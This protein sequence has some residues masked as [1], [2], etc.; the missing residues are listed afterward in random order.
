M[1]VEEITL[2]LP[3][4][5]GETEVVRSDARNRRRLGAAAAPLRDYRA[6]LRDC[7]R[8]CLFARNARK[9][10]SR[11]E[12]EYKSAMNQLANHVSRGVEHRHDR[13]KARKTAYNV[14]TALVEITVREREL[15]NRRSFEFV[16]WSTGLASVALFA[17][18]AV[19]W[20]LGN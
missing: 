7:N 15:R 18:L 11:F 3:G 12:K 2:G 17:N 19:W 4:E 16:R 8:F 13:A 20:W 14:L 10:R 9:R 5:T 6:A 1:A